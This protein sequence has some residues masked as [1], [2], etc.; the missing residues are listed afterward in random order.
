MLYSGVNSDSSKSK[1]S[2]QA[3]RTKKILKKKIKAKSTAPPHNIHKEQWETAVEIVNRFLKGEHLAT[4]WVILCAQPQEGKT[5]VAR[6]VSI[7]LFHSDEV[8]DCY[9]LDTSSLQIQKIYF[10]CGF[11]HTDLRK[12][13]RREMNITLANRKIPI[14]VFFGQDMKKALDNSDKGKSEFP[15][16]KDSLVI[17]DESHWG[18]KSNSVYH[19]FLVKGGIT[20]DADVSKWTTDNTYVISISATPMAEMVDSDV[21]ERGIDK[22]YVILKSADTY[23]SM[24]K[25]LDNNCIYQSKNLN[26]E[27]G[28]SHLTG[29]LEEYQSQRGKINRKYAVVRVPNEKCSTILKK[30]INDEL[31]DISVIDTH[32]RYGDESDLNQIVSTVPDKFTVIV[33]YDRLRAGV[34][35]DTSNISFVYEQKSSSSSAC[36]TVA[37]GLVGRCCGHNK[38]KNY[39]H[40]YCNVSS[41]TDYVDWVEN[42]YSTTHV[43]PKSKFIQKTKDMYFNWKRN[44][45]ILIDLP[46]VSKF[47]DVISNALKTD[48]NKRR[49][50]FYAE[51][52]QLIKKHLVNEAINN[53]DQNNPSSSRNLVSDEQL[54][55]LKEWLTWRCPNDGHGVTVFTNFKDAASKDIELSKYANGIK[56]WKRW[57]TSIKNC[58]DNQPHFAYH[59]DV[60]EWT[61]ENGKAGPGCKYYFTHINCD[62]RQ[63]IILSMYWVPDDE[64]EIDKK[65]FTS[66]DEC[67]HPDNNEYVDDT[68]G[69]AINAI[70]V[71]LKG[72][73]TQLQLS[74]DIV[75][76]DK[77]IVGKDKDTSVSKNIISGISRVIKN[78]GA[79][80]MNM[81]SNDVRK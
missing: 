72:Q 61:E 65:I 43:P 10:I 31:D 64:V 35:L 1:L 36:D 45:P 75:G 32:Y 47:D 24:K 80:L 15:D 67:F 71:D 73:N 13:A 8:P 28:I 69:Q 59:E 26:N 29:L 50:E 60:K 19:R 57:D 53:R 6:A 63:I 21:R 48:K 78:S 2:T 58:K 56:T 74:T 66:G 62:T 38:E 4:R 18:A 44:V 3:K 11:Q 30:K 68:E 42:N 81:Y 5:G 14:S 51:F 16:F 76:K 7:I 25:M 40:V 39:V 9:R 20:P 79:K 41:V 54:A 27:D 23:L 12:Q 49:G 34:Q 37:Q 77:D 46:P 55:N 17:I 33:I 70:D 52:N 22:E